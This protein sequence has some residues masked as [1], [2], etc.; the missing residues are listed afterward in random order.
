[1][2]SVCRVKWFT[3]GTRNYHPGVKRL[4]GDEDIEME[5]RKWLR[6]E[7]TDFCTEGFDALAKRWVKFINVGGGYVENFFRVRISHVLHPSVTYL[8]TLPRVQTHTHTH[9]HTHIYIY[10]YDLVRKKIKTKIYDT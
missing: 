8:L 4:A 5:V 7:S 6:Q 10:I 9:T 3:T 2:G 1:M